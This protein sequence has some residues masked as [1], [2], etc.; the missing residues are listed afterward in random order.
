MTAEVAVEVTNDGEHYSG[1]VEASV[2]DGDSRPQYMG[3]QHILVTTQL[4]DDEAKIYRNHKSF[5]RPPTFAVYTYVYPEYWY[6]NNAILEME[7]GYCQLPRRSEEGYRDREDGWFELQALDAAHVHLDWEHLPADL[8]YDQHFS[9]HL[10]ILPSRCKL[11]LCS[12][13][14]IR[15]SPEEF[16]PCEL[17]KEYPEWWKDTSVPKNVKNNMTIFALDDLIFKVEVHLLHGLYRPYAPLFKNTSTVRILQP[18]RALSYRGSHNTTTRQLSN[19]ISYEQRYVEM[20]YIF[21]AV[22][23]KEDTL[24]ISQALNMPPLYQAHEKGRALIMYNASV[25]EDIP[26]IIPDKDDLDAGTVFWDQ[27]ASTLGESKEM[28]DAYYETFHGTTY[29]ETGYL[30]EF[31]KM[32]LPYLPY[33]SNCNTYDSYIPFWMAVEDEIECGLPDDMDED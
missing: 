16:V 2:F 6:T 18:S 14:A 30:F 5:H 28:L 20:R 22:Y 32:L 31:E 24:S 17:S 8:I 7:K 21:V 23:L 4:E 25:R 33:F 3:G 27:P 1:G 12:S 11:E 19:F 26:V 29:S 9:L 10:S 13:T 15:L